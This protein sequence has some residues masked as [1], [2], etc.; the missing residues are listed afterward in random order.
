[1]E[2]NEKLQ[3]A[4]KQGNSIKIKYNGGS[5]PGTVREILPTTLSGGKLRATC[6]NS[7]SVKTFEIHK[8]EVVDINNLEENISWDK[9]FK[10]TQKYKDL[11][12]FFEQESILLQN[13]GYHINYIKGESISLHKI[14]KTGKIAVGAEL[15]LVFE[16][17]I[18]DVVINVF[19]NELET[20]NT[21]LREKPWIVRS[22]KINA[23]SYAKVEKAIEF[24]IQNLPN[25]QTNK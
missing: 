9:N 25:I 17:L 18:S 22:S 11:D 3:L 8:I 21:R 7:N 5:Q 13:T 4:I 14:F 2:I 1:M 10:P 24:F 16:E 19:N 15:A 23:R 20:I 12:D 6:F